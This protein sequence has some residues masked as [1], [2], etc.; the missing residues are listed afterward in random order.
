MT[1]TAQDVSQ[2]HLAAVVASSDDAICSKTLDGII[3]SW[4]RAAERMYGYPAAEA[5]GRPVA[6]LV[7]HDAED[8]VPHILARIRRGEPVRHCETVRRHKDGTRLPVGLTISPVRDASGAIVAASTI[9][10]DLTER[11]AAEAAIRR[12]HEELEARVAQRT[13]ELTAMNEELESFAHT[14]AHDLRAP[15]I[16]IAGYAETLLEDAAPDLDEDARRRLRLI[17]DNA[18]RMGHLID[19][20]MAFARLGRRA[21]SQRTVHPAAIARDAWT[22]LEGIRAGRPVDLRVGDLPP[23]R[24]DGALLKQVFV[25]LL[26]NAIK[27]SRGRDTPAVE[28]GWGGDAGEPGY[29][30]YFVKD[31]GVGFDREYAHKLF[32]IFQRL[33]SAD[34]FEGT[35]IGLATVHRIV[36]R[37][38]GR[39]WAEGDTGRGATFYFTLRQDT[40]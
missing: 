14:V 20:L 32:R 40:T 5:I 29:G 1:D 18:Q 8:E 31:N 33:H 27:F 38:G 12:A 35:G 37:H 6:M 21:V 3:L 24:A 25:N 7:P 22:E 9:A 19:G 23:C 11:Q 15:L 2:E 36:R 4:N 17:A 34:E 28:V 26:A 30:V 13:R 16:T 10:R 39:V